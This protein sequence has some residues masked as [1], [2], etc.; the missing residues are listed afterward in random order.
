MKYSINS[1]NSINEALKKLNDGD[2][3]FLENGIY[4]EK[5]IVLNNNIKI[6]GESKDQV[7]IRNHDWFC[8]IMEDYNECNTFRTYTVL[9]AG[10]NI[11]LENLTIENSCKP[12]SK[13]GQA[14]A[15]Y[16]EGDNFHAYNLNIK[17]AQDTLFTGPLPPD[18]IIRHQGFLPKYQLNGKKSKQIYDSCNIEG[19]VDFIF[20]TAEALFINCNIISIKRVC[21]SSIEGFLCAPA[22]SLDNKYGYLFYKCNLIS[23]G[24]NKNIFLARPWRDYGMAAFIECNIGNHISEL[25]FDKWN[26]TNRDKTA[27]F[28]EYNEKYDLSKRVKWA[29]ILNKEDKNKYINDFFKEVGYT[30]RED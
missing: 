23:E 12:S 25:G 26:N 2:I 28:Y 11:E 9:I 1:S 19:D 14:I 6:I 18:L 10:N 27:R 20:G 30:K 13:Y 7:I 15:L 24:N 17:G 8:K 22:Q 21:K 3:L 4:N 16:A 29:H 5:V